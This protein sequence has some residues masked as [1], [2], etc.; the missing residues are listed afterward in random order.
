MPHSLWLAGLS[1]LA[2]L[3]KMAQNVFNI[4]YSQHLFS[5]NHYKEKRS[6]TINSWSSSKE[7]YQ[8]FCTYERFSPTQ[9]M[10]MEI[11][12]RFKCTSSIF[13]NKSNTFLVCQIDK[14]TFFVMSSH[15][16]LSQKRGKTMYVRV[17]LTLVQRNVRSA[18]FRLGKKEEEIS[19]TLNGHRQWIE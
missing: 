6:R 13:E 3:R 7:I 17:W 9:A 1:R 16:F 12:T 10:N 14:R 19:E 4:G 18:I 11:T 5:W 15:S 8:F 2:T